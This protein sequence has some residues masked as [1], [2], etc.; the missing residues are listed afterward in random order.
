MN[1][2]ESPLILAV[3]DDDINLRLIERILSAKEYNTIT[4]TSGEE[5]FLTLKKI[6]PDLILL[7]VVM[8]EIDGYEVCSKLKENKKTSFIP[9]IFVTALE[10]EQ[11]KAKAFAVGAADYLVKPITRDNLLEAVTKHLKTKSQWNNFKKEI[12]MWEMAQP[13]DFTQFKDYLANQIDISPAKK[14]ELSQ[15]K[16]S[17]IYNVVDRF[18]LSIRE[19]VQYIVEFSGMKY[20]PTINP[21]SIQ[22][23]KL[24]TPFCQKNHV[25]PIQDSSGRDIFVISN[26]FDWELLDLLKSSLKDQSYELAIANPSSIASLFIAESLEKE[27][28]SLIAEPLESEKPII[29]PVTEMPESK[30]AKHPIITIANSILS[31]AV[32]ERASDIHLEPKEDHT[33]IRFRIDG[34]MKE[35][36]SIKKRT[37]AMLISRLKVLAGMD[38]AEKR[39]PQDGA[40]SAVIDNNTFNLRLAT[41]STV[42][43]ESLIIRLLNAYAKPKE[44]PELGMTEEQS[45]TLGQLINRNQGLILVVGPTGSGKTTTIYSLLHKIDYH[46]RSIVSVEDPVEYRIPF[47]NQEQVREKG[48]VTFETLLK[49]VVRQDPDVLFLGEIRDNYSATTAMNFASTGHL[50]ITSLHTT[51]A[52]TAIF[53]L[54]RLGVDRGTMADSFIGI[55]AQRLLKRLCSYCKKIVPISEEEKKLLAPYTHE[56]PQKVARPVGCPKCSRTG[57]YDREGIYEIMGFDP[58]ICDMVRAGVPISEIRS[59]SRKRGDFLISNHAIQKLNDFIF[60]PKDVYEKVLVEEVRLHEPAREAIAPKAPMEE[61]KREEK[62][63]ILVVEDDMDMRTLICRYLEN[64]GFAVTLAE[65]G[66]D[67]LLQ[68]GK[69]GYNLIISDVNMPELDGFRLLEMKNQ[70]GIETPVIFLTSRSSPEDER[71]GF[72]LGASDYLTKPI[73]KEKLL[74][75]VKNVIEKQKNSSVRKVTLR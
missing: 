59:F 38:I 18:N 47:I 46:T 3:D 28:L 31:S 71:R 36:S 62:A 64:I 7:D 17:E 15:V 35:M 29:M 60:S 75:R 42:R 26:P 37:A 33:V 73:Q 58:E 12:S 45:E 4:A 39:K 55:V 9:V 10:E 22:L 14:K 32:N 8:P 40:F 66:I 13:L 48:K 69:G 44:L 1:K 30:I 24:P 49:S 20:L 53:R 16:V 51:N 63:R 54:E 6:T 74:T 52:T 2:S 11:D 41:T 21:E 57:Y 65:D 34:D 61:K 72:E 19:L 67:A 68:L 50:S 43:G 70:K 27:K 23:G 25:V 5:A 56:I